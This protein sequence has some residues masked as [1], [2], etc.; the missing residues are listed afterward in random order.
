MIALASCASLTTTRE[1]AVKWVVPERPEIYRLTWMHTDDGHYCID[2]ANA[3]MLMINL[4]RLIKHIE[5]LED[6]IRAMAA[7]PE[8]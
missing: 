5:L 6:Q 3:E 7:I 1:A 8:P 4:D 2:E